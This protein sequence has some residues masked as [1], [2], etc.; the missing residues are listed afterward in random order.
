MRTVIIQGSSRKSKGHTHQIVE[1][2]QTQLENCAFVDLLDYT[3]H[4]YDY[5]HRYPEDDFMGVMRYI[6]EYDLKQYVT[7]VKSTWKTITYCLRSYSTIYRMT[8]IKSSS[9]YR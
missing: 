7:E 3:I 5:D 9:G 6:A 8:P 4:A 2:L 1:I